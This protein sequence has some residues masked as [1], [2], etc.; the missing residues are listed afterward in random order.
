MAGL[1]KV[2]FH[3]G[4]SATLGASTNFDYSK[5]NWGQDDG[6]G[7][8]TNTGGNM[9]QIVLPSLRSYFNVPSTADVFGLN[10]L[11]RSA[12]GAAKEDNSGANYFNP[13]NTGNYFTITNPA[14]SPHLALIGTPFNLTSTANTA[15]Q[16][17]TLEEVDAN[18]VVISQI[19][20]QTGGASFTQTITLSNTSLRAL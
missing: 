10:F 14:S 5:G 12:N 19:A 8:M 4:V 7:A 3:S 17:W 15:P 1:P 18:D 11:F 13:V 20:T 16:S 9:W 6:V 2:Y